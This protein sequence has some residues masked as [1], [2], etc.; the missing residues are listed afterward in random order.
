MLIAAAFVRKKLL[1]KAQVILD[2]ANSQYIQSKGK[3]I[4]EINSLLALHV[5]ISVH[6]KNCLLRTSSSN[7]LEF[8]CWGEKQ[9]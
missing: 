8:L 1:H 5:V 7:S 9:M 2:N 4:N 3:I 6:G